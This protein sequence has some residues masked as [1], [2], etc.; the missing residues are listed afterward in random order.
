MSID[1][2]DSKLGY[3]SSQ[4]PAMT[5]NVNGSS[6]ILH[7][8]HARMHEVKAGK[9]DKYDDSQSSDQAGSDGIERSIIF[10]TISASHLKAFIDKL[11]PAS[12]DTLS[13]GNPI[14]E[15]L[16]QQKGNM[17]ALTQEEFVGKYDAYVKEMMANDK[18]E[19]FKKGGKSSAVDADVSEFKE[20]D[21]FGLVRKGSFYNGEGNFKNI[22]LKFTTLSEGCQEAPSFTVDRKGAKIGK[23]PSNGICVPSDQRLSPEGHATIE[24]HRGSFYLVDGGY[25][26]SASIRI[27][28]ALSLLFPVYLEVCF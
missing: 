15:F 26:F 22:V 2:R 8:Y 3:S 28:M 18:I 12:D 6:K 10:N 11:N 21:S 1:S 7:D 4:N 17:K 14:A 19:E 13:R 24:Y 23:D 9:E 16:R 5:P 25:S 20:R 27:G